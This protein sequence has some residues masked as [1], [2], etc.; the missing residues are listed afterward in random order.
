MGRGDT[1]SYRGKHMAKMEGGVLQGDRRGKPK[2]VDEG[3][4]EN[5]TRLLLQIKAKFS[6]VTKKKK[7]N[8]F[9]DSKERETAM[10]DEGGK[11]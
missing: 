9:R 5:K 4:R 8:T 1:D 3:G 7:E 2:I 10:T 6:D 11:R